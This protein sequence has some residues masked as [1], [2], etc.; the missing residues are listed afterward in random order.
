MRANAIPIQFPVLKKADDRLMVAR[1]RQM[2][3]RI[4]RRDMGSSLFLLSTRVAQ[5]VAD[6]RKQWLF[7]LPVDD[8]NLQLGD[9]FKP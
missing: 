6:K 8:L 2:I 3:K 4:L 1:K 9:I 5:G 7:D